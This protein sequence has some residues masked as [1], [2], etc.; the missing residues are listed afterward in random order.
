V[1]G[2]VGKGLR[3]AKLIG[4]MGDD[5]LPSPSAPWTF[6]TLIGDLGLGME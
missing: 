4:K 6:K 1:S 2:I 5:G 3:Y